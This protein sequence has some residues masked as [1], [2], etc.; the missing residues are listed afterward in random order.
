[1]NGHGPAAPG[2]TGPARPRPSSRPHPSHPDVPAPDVPAPDVPAPDGPGT[3]GPGTG[4]PGLPEP[5]ELAEPADLVG[6]V[7]RVGPGGGQG[8]GSSGGL[9]GPPLH[10]AGPEGPWEEVH[11]QLTGRGHVLVHTT[12]GQWLAAALLDPGLRGLLGRDWPRYR[13]TAAPAGRLRFAASR[14]VLKHTAAAALQLPADALDLAYRPGGR[15]H[16][17]GLAGTEVSL[18][19]TDELIVVA[20]SRTGP[21][22]VDA[23][24]VTRRPSFELLHPYVC[25]PAEAA[26]LA[27]LPE[28]D[29]T[30]RLLHLWTLK[31][32]YTKALGH[33]MRRRFA[34]FGFSR[35]EQ[36]RTVLADEPAGAPRWIL[37]THLVHGRYLVSAAHHPLFP[38]ETPSR[39]APH[40]LEE[41]GLP[42]AAT[43][44]WPLP[45]SSGAQPT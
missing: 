18:A 32:A 15:P 12:W 3:G 11:D 37:A 5:A 6:R 23:E 40:P 36:G 38:V 35:D 16:L 9:L 25:T 13:Q 7:G 8:R 34:A 41:T 33:G 27:A 2:S 26:E 43:L 45:G 31:E 4:G 1:M 42:P 21:I 44:G 20:V 10:V 30:A 24:P 39:P 17:R 14:M 29:R 28:D 19:H 22:G